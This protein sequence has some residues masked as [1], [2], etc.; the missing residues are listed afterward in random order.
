MLSTQQS[1][2]ELVDWK[3]REQMQTSEAQG[4][5][6]YFIPQ[7]AE[8]KWGAA[9][10]TGNPAGRLSPLSVRLPH[11]P[12]GKA[13]SPTP[14]TRHFR[15]CSPPRRVPVRRYCCIHR[16]I[17]SPF[18]AGGEPLPVERR[19]PPP[20]NHTGAIRFISNFWLFSRALLKLQQE[21]S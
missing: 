15:T 21:F 16:S 10:E 20:S 14:N 4:P 11:C 1:N 13:P 3:G 7:M 9:C 5:Q 18:Q 6:L 17:S 8:G 19:E 12:V 2:H